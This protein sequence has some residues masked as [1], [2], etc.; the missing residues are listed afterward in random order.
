MRQLVVDELRREEVERIRSYLR[1]H[2]EASELDDLFWLRIPDDLLSEAQIGHHDCS[3]FYFAVE[4]GQDWVKLEFLVRTR[5]R[6]RCSCIAYATPQQRQ[7][8][9][10]FC[11]TMLEKLE[12][13]T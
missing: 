9:L 13:N 7:F 12:I 4:L 5:S 1:Q 11:D 3:P 10:R 2:C 6:L 8:L